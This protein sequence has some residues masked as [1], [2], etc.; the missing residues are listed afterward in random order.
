MVI[1][2]IKSFEVN[3]AK[4]SAFRCKQ[5]WVKHG[6]ISSK[7]YFNL[8]KRNFLGKTMYIVH[9]NDVSL[10]KDYREILNLQYSFYKDLYTR[11][12]RIKFGLVNES[13]TCIDYVQRNLMEET[14]SL[15]ECFDA[16]MT[17]KRGKM[18][19]SDG[20]GL[21]FYQK[22]WSVLKMPLYQMYLA[23]IESG[24]LNPTGRRG[25]INLIPKKG[26]DDLLIK[27]WRPITLLNY[28]YKIWAKA[29]A[30]HLEVFTGTLIGKQQSGFMKGRSIFK[31]VKK[32]MEIVSYL[33]ITNTPGIIIMIDFEKCF[34]RIEHNSI[35]GAMRYFGFGDK[36]IGMLILLYNK[37][38]MCTVSNWLAV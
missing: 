34:D 3:D 12:D 31:N 32:T 22:F 18:P 37:L 16:M 7:Y 17:L 24:Q 9:Q 6:E 23:A 15:E 21:S 28:D 10:T 5:N 20:L 35:A 1:K 11:D 19:G 27:N 38:E 26:K 33:N 30:N 8:E 36:F 29:L 14:I 2:E 13:G 25:I 4:C